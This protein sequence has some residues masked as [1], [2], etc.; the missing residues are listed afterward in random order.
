MLFFTLPLLTAATLHGASAGIAVEIVLERQDAAVGEPLAM[1]IRVSGAKAAQPPDL[2]GLDGFT[3]QERGG[4]STSSTSVTSVNGAW[5][6]ITRLG[7]VFNYTVTPLR[8]GRLTIPALAVIVEGTTYRTAPVIV[9]VS[10]PR[11]TDDLKLRL[12]LSAASCYVGQ[13]VTMTVTWFVGRDV[14]DFEFQL[15]LL[16]DDRF[17][18]TPLPPSPGDPGREQL[19]IPLGNAALTAVKGKGELD[20]R[21]FLTVTFRYLLVPT[22]AGS[23][24]LPR[25]TV[26][27]RTLSVP[28]RSPGHGPG[29]GFG[30]LDDF[31]G[32]SQPVARTRVIPS[33]AP[34][35][36]VE[37]LPEA[38]RPADFS[39]LVGEYA[40]AAE[41]APRDMN[42]GDPVTLTLTISGAHPHRA[43]LPD[44]ARFL[45]PSAFKIPAEMA[46]AETA[47]DKKIFTQTIRVQDPAV[48]AI[49]PIDLSYFD[50]VQKNYRIARSAAVPL[51]VHPTRVVTATDA[52]GGPAAAGSP[53]KAAAPEI[54]P[55]AAAEA[56]LPDWRAALLFLARRPQLM[57]VPFLFLCLAVL[58]RFL[59]KNR[60]RNAD[61]RRARRALGRLERQLAAVPPAPAA[62]SAALK[63]YLGVKLGKNSGALTLPDVEPAL[64]AL[65]VSEE[66][67]A[68]LKL[69]LA[70]YD[71][72]QYGGRRDICADCGRLREQT[73]AVARRLDPYLP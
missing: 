14:S 17:E 10:E 52:E 33:N 27:C 26:A 31:F 61:R 72:W 6:R 62:L 60:E 13:A 44:L 30:G 39:G 22:Q 55:P 53:E 11:E 9:S 18:L 38:G 29:S 43:Q 12:Q 15:P 40:M 23:L 4:Q 36:L 5:E 41:A 7:Y 25:A 69:L 47:E 20:G 2:S 58:L 46:A 64:R 16:A 32:S 28:Q 54:T 56:L 3:V 24:T 51:T 66:I 42:V 37:P 57:A 34:A 48:T 45:P 68:E 65:G 71:A 59:Q 73:L 49:P 21:E 63:Q 70:Q 35:L 50:P 8:A 67:I 19:R 1:Q